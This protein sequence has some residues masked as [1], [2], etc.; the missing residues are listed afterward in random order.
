VEPP[1]D[2]SA[3]AWGGRRRWIGDGGDGGAAAA[4]LR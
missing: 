1:P 4:G 2:G 3:I